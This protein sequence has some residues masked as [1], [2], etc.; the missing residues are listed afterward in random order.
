MRINNINNFSNNSSR[1][2]T[3]FCALK[4]HH[5]VFNSVEPNKMLKG[6]ENNYIDKSAFKK[7]DFLKGLEKAGKDL[8]NTKFLD[9]YINADGRVGIVDKNGKD[10]MHTMNKFIYEPFQHSGSNYGNMVPRY[11]G[12]QIKLKPMNDRYDMSSQELWLDFEDA[13]VAKDIANSWNKD[14]SNEFLYG[15]SIGLINRMV[16][17]LKIIERSMS[18]IERNSKVDD[19]IKKNLNEFII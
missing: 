17:Y 4:I 14:L 5:D 1:V 2:N 9:L 13:Q 15:P 18:Y 10:I 16:E 6:L 12:I 7:L 3:N 11:N 19:F 8:Q